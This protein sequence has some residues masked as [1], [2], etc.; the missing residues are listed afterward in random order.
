MIQVSRVF[1]I[2][3]R[4][5]TLDSGL[6]IFFAVALMR[7]AAYAEHILASDVGRRDEAANP[8]SPRLV[9]AEQQPL[10]RRLLFF[11]G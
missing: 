9:N 2:E 4:L 3:F 10:W 11:V 7:N 5:Q 1:A 8:L 6:S